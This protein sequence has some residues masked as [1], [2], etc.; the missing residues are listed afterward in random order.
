MNQDWEYC[1]VQEYADNE[2]I[3]QQKRLVFCAPPVSEH[4]F[5][6]SWSDVMTLLGTAGWRFIGVDLCVHPEA[7]EAT[8]YFKRLVQPGQLPAHVLTAEAQQGYPV[9]VA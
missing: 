1:W 2:S 6:R 7:Y 9:E 8:V 5:D 4:A 3:H